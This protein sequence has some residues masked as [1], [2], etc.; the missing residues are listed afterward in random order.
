VNYII[1]EVATVLILC[2][3]VHIFFNS[4]FGLKKNTHAKANGITIELNAFVPPDIKISA[5]DLS[6]I[7]GN[8]FDNAIEEC[9]LL[10]P[11]ARKITA[12][13]T[14]RNNMIFYEISN[15]C[16]QTSHMK[17]GRFRG[18]GLENVRRCVEKYSGTMEHGMSN[19]LYRVSIRLNCALDS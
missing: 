5:I 13:I 8:T 16:L 6:V 7:I 11:S 9:V 1:F 18:Y 17:K 14:Q 19:N 4:W 2:L 3:L 10:E 12:E 15:P